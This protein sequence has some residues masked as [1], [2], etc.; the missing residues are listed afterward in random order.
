VSRSRLSAALV[1]PAIVVW[2]SLPGGAQRTQFSQD[3]M[4][5]W[6][7]YIASD[8]LQGR[9]VFTEGLGLAGAYIAEQLKSFGVAPAGDSGSY[10]QTVKVLGMR[11][12]SNSSVTVT[13]NGETRTFKDGQGVSFPRNQGGKQTIE[14]AVEFVGY[15][16]QF[17]P[18]NHDDY[19]HRDMKGKIALFI[20]RGIRG[21]TAAHNRLINARARDATERERALASI[22]PV[23]PPAGR[24]RG[25]GPG[26]P[27]PAAGSPDP[28]AGNRGGN[29]V[30][31][32]AAAP[33][34]NQ[35]QRTDFQT[36][37]NVNL[38]V[39]PQITATD[40]F[41]EFLFAGS[42][43]TYEALKALA[44]K[45]EPLPEIALGD[46]R[47][48]I[49]V[50]ADYETVQTRLT[51]NVVGVVRGTD[52]KLRDTYV[53]LGAHY[54]HVGYQ[55]FAP[56]GGGG[57]VGTVCA[58]Q[59]RPTPRPGD[60]ISNGA[61]DDGSGTVSLLA[62]ARAFATGQKPKRSLMFVWHSGE[63][64]GLHGSRYMAD[65]PVLPIQ[66]MVAML[67][68]DMV[69][70]N[71]CDDQAQSNTVYVVGSERI[72]TELHNVNEAANASLPRPLTLDYEYNDVADQES[73][74]TRS[75]H[76]SYATK[77]V[78]VIFFTTGLHRDYHQVTDEVDKIEFGKMA[79]V[80]ELIHAT[81]MRVAN[82]DHPPQRDFA[83]PRVG[84]GKTGPIR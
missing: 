21:M 70:R 56:A 41:F 28:A 39:P 83:G 35:A 58:G 46:V 60:A 77:G 52:A 57:G 81:A 30:P 1:G 43:Y 45:Q 37:R 14:A 40:E 33:A 17:A 47:I 15:G 7:T 11:T 29:A 55:Q 65:N 27:A 18:L 54:D 48:T 6:L 31:P 16:I 72:S 49:T 13:A 61:D 22:G 32:A 44:A 8:A 2:L 4:K 19:A 23:A 63:E 12:R 42:G 50:D 76:Y 38:P 25:A 68:V 34:T 71:R 75:D 64:D 36:A 51:R 53:G 74:Y 73:L 82:L 20:G 80:A 66:Q 79:R 69:G 10:F 9:Q 24:G 78:P 84:K 59:A 3:E 62:I 26:G 67:N 5:Q